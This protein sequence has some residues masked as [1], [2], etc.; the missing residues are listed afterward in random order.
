[1][2]QVHLCIR[3]CGFHVQPTVPAIVGGYLS[4]LDIAASQPLDEDI[5]AI[6]MESEDAHAKL[7]QSTSTETI[8]RHRYEA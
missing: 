1:M 5:H 3:P 2:M 8:W 4:I 6:K 7:A